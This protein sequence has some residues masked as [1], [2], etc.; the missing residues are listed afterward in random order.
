V[1][2][3]G[4]LLNLLCGNAVDAEQ[5]RHLTVEQHDGQVGWDKVDQRPGHLAGYSDDLMGPDSLS[6]GRSFPYSD[7]GPANTY[8]V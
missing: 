5:P 4:C 3:T 6:K 2:V 1:V 7:N 8:R